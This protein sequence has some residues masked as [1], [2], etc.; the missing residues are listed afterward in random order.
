[1]WAHSVWIL[2]VLAR[3]SGDNEVAAFLV[4]YMPVGIHRLASRP[5][6][7]AFSFGCPDLLTAFLIIDLS[8]FSFEACEDDGED[9]DGDGEGAGVLPP[10]ALTGM[11]YL[12]MCMM[13]VF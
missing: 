11:I 13:G 4:S 10:F 1:M 7:I 5:R 12:A 9:A 2:R 3:S 6:Q 8:G